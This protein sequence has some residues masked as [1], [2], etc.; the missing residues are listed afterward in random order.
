LPLRRLALGIIK[1]IIENKKD[2]KIRDLISYSAGLYL[3]QG[4]EFENKSLQTELLNFLMDRLKF[5]MKEEKIRTDIIQASTSFLNLDQSVIVL[6][7][8]KV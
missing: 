8:P 3:D 1:T 4:F 2:F 5:Y 6:V 7:R